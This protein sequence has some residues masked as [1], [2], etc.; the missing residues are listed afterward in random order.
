MPGHAG[1]KINEWEDALAAY[2]EVATPLSVC[3]T[4]VRHLGNYTSA[5][6]TR[7]LQA[8]HNEGL[9]LREEDVPFG[10]TATSHQK[11]LCKIVHMALADGMGVWK[12]DQWIMSLVNPFTEGTRT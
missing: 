12:D 10:H 11:G 4:D 9:H 6:Q 3:F 8:E 5:K 7:S 2:A 1:V